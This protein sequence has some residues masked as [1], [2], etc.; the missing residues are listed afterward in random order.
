[1]TRAPAPSR[2]PRPA[3][4]SR[5]RLPLPAWVCGIGLLVV[6]VDQATKAWAVAALDG[7]GRVA[8]LGDLL[9]LVLVH[10]P[11][12]AFSFLSGRTWLFTLI[13]AVVVVVVLRAARRVGS[14]AWAVALGLV[15]GGAVGNLV[16][17]IVREPGPLRGHVVDFIDY[18]GRFVGNVA[19]IAI[20]AAAV[21]IIVLTTR[22]VGVDGTMAAG[23]D[24][25]AGPDQ[26]RAPA[27]D[28]EEE[29]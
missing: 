4:A 27:S 12:A 13:A 1:M 24:P 21:L 14:P 20:V 8:L 29:R 16:D 19:D 22:G 10:N 25:S 7:Q 17:R 11:G 26:G 3:P 23:P 15:L 2:S 6:A 9:G 28:R 18:G 5:R